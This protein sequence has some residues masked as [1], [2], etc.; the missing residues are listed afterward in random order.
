MRALVDAHSHTHSTATPRRTDIAP[1]R[2]R[3]T[4]VAGL[5]VAAGGAGRRG[6]WTGL[7]GLVGAA[8]AGGTRHQ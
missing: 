6:L 1:S 8:A 4:S 7:V 2:E 3:T 5:V